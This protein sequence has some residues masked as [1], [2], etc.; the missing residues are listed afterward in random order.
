M[1]SLFPALLLT[2]CSFNGIYM[3]VV[4]YSEASVSCEEDLDEN[5]ERGYSP[6]DE[7][8]GGGEWTYDDD[9]TGA[10]AITF[11]HISPTSGGAVITWG[12]AAYPG[13]PEGAGWTFSWEE[14]T[15][16]FENAEHED[17]YEYRE[18][19][20]S[21]ST[22]SIHI[23]QA[24]FGEVTGT[25]KS[26]G[27]SNYTYIESDEWDFE[28]TDFSTGA[29]PSSTYLVYKEDGELYPQVNDSE[30]TDC[31]DKECFITLSTTCEGDPS[32]FTAQ[33]VDGNDVLMYN[34]IKDDAQ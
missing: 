11:F 25:I 10:D 22:V 16:G 1:F 21:S 27:T 12:D 3:I 15:N 9:F 29:I 4:P 18:E 8:G 31:E 19:Y 34:D 30:E 32:S 13:V 6:V 26:S 24:M 2:G 5:F 33:H 17:G 7:E 28:D 23:E 14:A 20:D